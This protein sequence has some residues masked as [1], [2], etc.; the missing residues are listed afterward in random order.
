VTPREVVSLALL[1]ATLGTAGP[2][3]IVLTEKTGGLWPVAAVTLAVLSA[4]GMGMWDAHTGERG[5]RLL[6]W[7]RSAAQSV[8]GAFTREG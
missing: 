3:A 4:Y 6:T 2:V 1:G 5:A 8:R 7:A